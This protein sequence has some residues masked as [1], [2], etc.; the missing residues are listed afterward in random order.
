MGLPKRPR[1]PAELADFVGR[2]TTLPTL[3]TGWYA[4]PVFSMIA[5]YGVC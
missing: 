1:D 5:S 4:L 2:D 3:P